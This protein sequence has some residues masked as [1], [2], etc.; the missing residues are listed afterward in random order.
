M[1]FIFNHKLNA[2]NLFQT[3]YPHPDSVRSFRIGRG[4]GVVNTPTDGLKRIE[5]PSV[6]QQEMK[7]VL[8]VQ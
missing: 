4:C 5:R 6:I 2:I 3:I 7:I 1:D 8:R